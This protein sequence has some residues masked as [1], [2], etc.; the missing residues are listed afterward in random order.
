MS[1]HA[2]TA[3][4]LPFLEAVLTPARVAHSI[5][6]MRVMGR[7]AEVYG[8]DRE[9]AC[10]AGLLHDVAKDLDPGLQRSLVEK[11]D[12]PLEHACEEHPVYLHAAAGAVV[13]GS[14]LGVVD[15]AVIGAIATHSYAGDRETREALLARCLRV[16]DLLAPID[17]WEGLAKLSRVAEEGRIDEASLLHS[18]WVIEYFGERGVPVHPN[19]LATFEELSTKLEVDES[20]YAR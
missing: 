15:G 17:E 7:F 12:F 6:V 16:A 10:L 14:E 3:R 13:A 4:R 11:A 19:L 20:F 2:C 9:A 8:L 1:I 18:A 5:R